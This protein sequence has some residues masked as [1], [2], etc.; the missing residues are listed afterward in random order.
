M[1]LVQKRLLK[2]GGLSA[3]KREL[4]KI[5]NNPTMLLKTKENQSDN[6]TNPTMLMKT[7]NLIFRT[8][9]VYENRGD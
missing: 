1:L 8:H 4:K 5:R 3:E 6:L 7:N 9:D 2:S